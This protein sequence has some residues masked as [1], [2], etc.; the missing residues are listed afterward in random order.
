M[1]ASKMAKETRN[2][3]ESNAG[4]IKSVFAKSQIGSS[5]NNDAVF[6]KARMGSFLFRAALPDL[7][8]RVLA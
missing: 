1:L 2:E 3:A 5:Q 4:K 6:T 8:G 7:Q